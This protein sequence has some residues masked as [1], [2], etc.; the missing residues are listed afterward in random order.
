MSRARF[1]LT[2]TL[3][4]L[5]TGCG[6][7]N[8]G[9][10]A[11]S[12]GATFHQ[13]S[14]QQLED[15]LLTVDDMPAGYSQDPPDNGGATATYCGTAPEHAPIRPDHGF[16]KGSGFSTEVASIQLS[17]YLSADDAARNLEVLRSALRSCKSEVYQ[18]ERV[19][20]S[21]VSTPRLRYP[22]LGI[23]VVSDRYTALI[24]VAQVGP[25]IVVAGIAGITKADASLASSML[26]TQV[27]RYEDAALQ[28][29]TG[30]NT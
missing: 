6:G 27:S 12:G 9:A 1:L 2:L 28:K 26:T 5:L 8:S 17:Q 24:D 7:G 25:T 20:Y 30:S 21:Q 18:G 14:E 19:H 13:L 4:V 15:L 29:G 22:T 11:G 3:L 10:K 23:R 16:T